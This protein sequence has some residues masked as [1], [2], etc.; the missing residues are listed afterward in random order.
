MR[1]GRAGCDPGHPVPVTVLRPVPPGWGDRTARSPACRRHDRLERTAP[2]R[3]PQADPDQRRDQHMAQPEGGVVGSA[4]GVD[5]ERHHVQRVERQRRSPRARRG[6]AP[7]G[8]PTGPAATSRRA[9]PARSR[10]CA[11]RSSGLPECGAS[12]ASHH[13]LSVGRGAVAAL[14]RPRRRARPHRLPAR[15][16]APTPSCA[17][18]ASTAPAASRPAATRKPAA[19]RAGRRPSRPAGRSSRSAPGS[20]RSGRA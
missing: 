4:A 19:G 1:I 2:A 16:A 15:A 20:S 17:A 10:W 14:R 11:A 6:P 18:T 3:R 9:R 13:Q 7:A 8:A 5:R 12:T